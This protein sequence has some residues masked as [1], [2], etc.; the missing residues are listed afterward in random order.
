MEGKNILFGG[1]I[2]GIAI[3]LN[4][5]NVDQYVKSMKRLLTLTIDILCEGHEHITK[6]ADLVS[7]C[8]R[9]YMEFNEKLNFLIFENITTKIPVKKT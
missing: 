8:I 9:G 3:N 2:P 4:D 7:K 5:G 6:S 1:D